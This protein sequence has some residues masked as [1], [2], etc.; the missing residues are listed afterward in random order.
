MDD[1]SPRLALLQMFRALW[2]ILPLRPLPILSAA[3]WFWGGG[4]ESLSQLNFTSRCRRGMRS[5]Q[6]P[7][8]SESLHTK[9]FKPQSVLTPALLMPNDLHSYFLH[10]LGGTWRVQ[11]HIACANGHRRTCEYTQL[12]CVGKKNG[13]L[14]CLRVQLLVCALTW[15]VLAFQGAPGTPI[16][17]L[18][19]GP[20]VWSVSHRSWVNTP[21]GIS[22]LWGKK[23]KKGK[24][25]HAICDL[26]LVCCRG[27]QDLLAHLAHLGLVAS[28]EPRDRR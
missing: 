11:L 21:L 15:T 22:Q 6:F 23:K 27:H 13:S 28:L 1:T 3:L 18:Q 10:L 26:V 19:P 8:S 25:C 9:V 20:Q 14:M 7:R 5:V 4:G 16:N 12:Y 2:H 24:L 17:T